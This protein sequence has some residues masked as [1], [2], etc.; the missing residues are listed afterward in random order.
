MESLI[1]LNSRSAHRK[2]D[3]ERQSCGNPTALC[4]GSVLCEICEM[5]TTCARRLR[6]AS[7]SGL[8]MRRMST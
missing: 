4:H 1:S 6:L 3:E 8:K 2:A 7:V 5:M